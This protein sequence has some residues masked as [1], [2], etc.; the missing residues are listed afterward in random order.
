MLN[1]RKYSYF[2]G[3]ICPDSNFPEKIYLNHQGIIK[4]MMGYDDNFLRVYEGANK[5]LIRL[6]WRKLGFLPPSFFYGLSF[7]PK[8]ELAYLAIDGRFIKFF[9]IPLT[10][11]KLFEFN[12]PRHLTEKNGVYGVEIGVK[13]GGINPF[14]AIVTFPRPWIG[15]PLNEIIKISQESPDQIVE[16]LQDIGFDFRLSF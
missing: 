10:E 13:E 3:P 15:Y 7:F 1:E 8:K 6:D 2:S 4:E 9:G 11:R 14:Q 16:K 12:L 5:D